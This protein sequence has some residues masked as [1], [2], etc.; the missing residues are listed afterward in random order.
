[1]SL[2]KQVILID[3]KDIQ[4]AFE[5]ANIKKSDLKEPT[6]DNNVIIDLMNSGKINILEKDG[7]VKK[8]VISLHTPSISNRKVL[9]YDESIQKFNLLQGTVAFTS[10]SLIE[11]E[12]SDYDYSCQ[13]TAYFLT[14]AKK[15]KTI[16]IALVSD[17]PEREFKER[18]LSDRYDFLLSRVPSNS[19]LFVDGPLIGSQSSSKNIKLV[20]ALMEKGIIPVFYVKNSYSRMLIDNLVG[21]FKNDHDSDLD[22]VNKLLNVGERTSF[23]YYE[24]AFSNK[25]IFCYVKAYDGIPQRFEMYPDTFHRY[26]DIIEEITSMI[27]YYSLLHGDVNNPQIRPIAIAERFARESLNYTPPYLLIK[28]MGLD[29]TMN[30]KRGFA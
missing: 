14:R 26:T 18:Y 3:S 11:A 9:A 20:N 19:L 17:Q 25:K 1:M 6:I 10:H 22:Y 23:V 2:D 29:E 21:D 8:Y 5:K 24:D 12:E 15:Y 30:S 4:D 7:R 13:L 16:K 27:Y 28:T